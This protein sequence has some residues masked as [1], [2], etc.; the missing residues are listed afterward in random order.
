MGLTESFIERV[1]F[2]GP[3]TAVATGSIVADRVRR[4]FVGRDQAEALDM[5]ANLASSGFGVSLHVRD[6][7][8]SSDNPVEQQMRQYLQLI[9]KLSERIPAD[10]EV[11]VKLEQLGLH[12]HGPQ[13][14][15]MNLTELARA[16]AAAGIA[17]TVDM[18]SVDEVDA[19][20]TTWASAHQQVTSLGIAIQAY[21]PRSETDCLDLAA[22]GARVR[23]CKGGYS[24]VPGVT[25]DSKHEVDR[26]YVRC[27]DALLRNGSYAMFATHDARMARI[28]E[29]LA[30]AADRGG[31]DW[32]Y[33]MLQGMRPH[34]MAE[35]A[36]AGHHVRCYIAFGEDWYSWFIGR[37]SE[38]PS[39]VL[40]LGRAVLGGG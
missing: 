12:T 5:A 20:L 28:V 38:N 14:A 32:E 6:A 23:L 30:F 24:R 15:A 7:K 21:L 17:M 9:E 37:L 8:V 11:S 18:E 3:V 33:Q 16:A 19:T 40:L 39:N 29:Y 1:G 31:L 35:L 27:A 26:S 13:A 2:S 22:M 25:Y 10:A 36:A 4:R 34:L